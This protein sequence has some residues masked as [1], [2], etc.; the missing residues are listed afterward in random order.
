MWHLT[1]TDRRASR[2][3]ADPAARQRP[4]RRP[5]RSRPRIRV[6]DQPPSSLPYDDSGRRPTTQFTPRGFLRRR[7]L[8]QLFA[9]RSDCAFII[10]THDHDLPLGHVEA[11]TL[12]LRAC[13]FEGGHIRH[14]EVDELPAGAP[15][16]DILK[17]DL[18]GARRKVLF[19]EGTEDSLDKALYSLVFPMVSIIPRGNCRD[20]ERAV[21]GA[22]AA[23]PLHWLQVFGIVDSDGLDATQIAAKRKRGVYALPYYSVEALYFHSEIIKRISSRQADLLGDDDTELAEMAITSGT[24]AIRSHTDRLCRTATKKALRESV[25]EQIPNDDR[26]LAGEKVEIAND[27]IAAHAE[28]VARLEAAVAAGDWDTILTACSV[29]ETNALDS[30][31]AKLGFRRRQD[32]QRAVRQMLAQDADA[33]GFVRTL[34]GDLPGQII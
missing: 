19:I 23:E 8:G 3:L 12:L 7:L 16:D 20:V 26:L 24:D 15:V 29:R 17:R 14:W 11:R 13:D 2:S 10:S 30:I 34:F 31:S 4:V 27:A 33:L 18:L 5:D 1:A 28:R 6:V 21:I 32:Y 22:R 9:F 25:M